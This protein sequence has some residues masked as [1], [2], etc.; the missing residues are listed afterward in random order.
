MVRLTQGANRAERS[1]AVANHQRILEAAREVFARRGLAAEIRDIAERAGVGIGTLYRHF[2][3][4]EGLLAALIHQAGDDLLR[5]TQAV[6]ETE[7]PRAA[8]RAMIH[9]AAEVCERFGA[10][11]EVLLTSEIDKFHPGGHAEFR[12]LLAN[13]LRRGVRE[14]V[15]HSDLDVPVA[16]AALESVFTSGALLEL[17]AQR[18][19]PGAADAIADFFLQALAKRPSPGVQASPDYPR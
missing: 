7:G 10:L 9:A 16:V 8:L 17:A 15:F 6:A 18:S 14:E 5:R 2:E 19:Y 12:E 11:T 3:S 4:R 1:D 13:L